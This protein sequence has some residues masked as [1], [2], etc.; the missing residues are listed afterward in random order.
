MLFIKEDLILYI[1]KTY[2]TKEFP[3]F[4]GMFQHIFALYPNLKRIKSST[5][6]SV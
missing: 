2:D 1:Q 4:E 3:T 5:F 6:R